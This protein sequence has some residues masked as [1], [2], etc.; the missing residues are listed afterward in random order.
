MFPLGIAVPLI[1]AL[2]GQR[3]AASGWAAVIGCVWTVLLVLKLAGYTIAATFPDSLFSALDLLTPSGHVA[4]SASIYGGLIGLL[5]SRPGTLMHRSVLAAIVVAFAI[6][7]TRVSLGV[8]SL[9]EVIVG[10]MVG[11][12]G[13]AALACIVRAA[14]ARQA[15]LPIIASTLVIIATFHGDHTTWE[16]TI[17][18]TALRITQLWSPH[19]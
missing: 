14:I 11:V 6:G 8:H 1:L 18:D 15:R 2:M 12:A 4:S 7:T 9:S 5:L 13:A 19:S 3:R 16:E 10:G 17:R